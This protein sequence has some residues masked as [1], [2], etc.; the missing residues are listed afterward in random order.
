MKAIDA[1]TFRL[2]AA[3]AL[4]AITSCASVHAAP[5]KTMG[6]EGNELVSNMRYKQAIPILTQ[7]LMDCPN[8]ANALVDLACSY[9]CLGDFAKALTYVNLAINIAPQ[10][11]SAYAERSALASMLGVN[12]VAKRD[13]IKSLDL[14]KNKDGDV[15]YWRRR[16]GLLLVANKKSEAN[17]ALKT[18]Q[19]LMVKNDSVRSM[20][21][22]IY[23][24]RNLKQ[25]E[26]ALAIVNAA[27][28]KYPDIEY[29]L[30]LKT[31]LDFNLCNWKE[32]GK[33]AE[34][35]LS[36]MPNHPALLWA[37]AYAKMANK[38]YYN[39]IADLDK[40]IYF[41]PSMSH[42]YQI[43]G[44]CYECLNDYKQAY[45]D[46]SICLSLDPKN[47]FAYH[48]RGHTLE[49]L[50]NLPAATKD[51]QRRA[52]I[53]PKDPE[54]FYCLGHYYRK[55]KMFDQSIAAYDQ[56]IKLNPK[57]EMYFCARGNAKMRA[58][59]Y[60]DSIAD[61][62]QSLKLDSKRTHPRYSRGISYGKLKQ[63]DLAIKDLSE[64]IDMD[65]GYGAAYFQRAQ[66]YK[67]MGKQDDADRDMQSAIKY[68]YKKSDDMQ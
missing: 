21:D 66:I 22:Q 58:G 54:I 9:R 19:G 33:D 16:Y 60:E 30:Y 23:I 67:A 31:G 63:Y 28:E 32:L 37:S 5:A 34:N 25:S 38:K 57:N 17:K 41:A 2:F 55:H 44:Q 18:A 48:R 52:L 61:C 29:F 65:S 14:E 7:Y 20:A 53:Y 40:A 59:K 43:R 42:S 62:T 11:A 68:K 13:A 10:S 39:A 4:A 24:L 46:Y 50:D 45:R 56:A 6:D 15:L 51:L 26:A 49:S 36:R 47:D 3:Y 12:Q 64:A 1:K 27:I 8:D 35:A